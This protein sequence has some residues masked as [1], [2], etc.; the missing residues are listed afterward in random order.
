VDQLN[1]LETRKVGMVS[2]AQCAAVKSFLLALYCGSI[3]VRSSSP[4]DQYG[5]ADL[6]RGQR[7]QILDF[8]QTLTKVRSISRFYS[9]PLSEFISGRVHIL[10]EAFRRSCSDLFS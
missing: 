6:G 10:D 4:N 5:Y 8:Q 2:P 7:E 3:C 1:G 9:V